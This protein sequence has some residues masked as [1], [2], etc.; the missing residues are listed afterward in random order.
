MNGV[1]VVH[2]EELQEDGL[3]EVIDEEDL[4][5]VDREDHAF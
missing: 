4:K 2:A 3:D 5:S 1:G